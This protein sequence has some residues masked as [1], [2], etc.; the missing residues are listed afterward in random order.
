MS[1]LAEPLIRTKLGPPAPRERVAREALLERLL[2]GPRRLTVV[3]APAGSGK[4][5]LLA[6]WCAD[7]REPR[8]FAWLGLDAADNDPVRCS[9]AMRS[10]RCARSRPGWATGALALLAA[11]GVDLTDEMLPLLINELADLPEPLVLVLDDYHLI[12]AAEVHDGVTLLLD[13]LP[14]Q[15][16]LVLASRARAAARRLARLRARRRAAASS[17]PGAQLLRRGG[18]ACC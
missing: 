16:E 1:G 9:G 14:P 2:A 7:E 11:P 18:R 4:T 10:R 5:T 15:L 6:E 8:P 12:E 3:R 17:T 13:H